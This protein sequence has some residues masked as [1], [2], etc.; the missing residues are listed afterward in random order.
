MMT[1]VMMMMTIVMMMMIVRI[2]IEMIM[3]ITYMYN[4]S[5]K[6]DNSGLLLHHL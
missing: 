5:R 3:V 2:M 6:L 4:K 1:I